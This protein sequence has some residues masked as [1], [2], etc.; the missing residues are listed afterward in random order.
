MAVGRIG[1]LAALSPAV[2]GLGQLLTGPLSDRWGRKHLITA[3]M[4]TQVGALAV[5]AAAGTFPLW[6]LAAVMLGAGTAMAYPDPS[7]GH[8]TQHGASAKAARWP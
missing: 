8:T 4:L 6:A 7:P 5:I 1:V 3:G 2:W